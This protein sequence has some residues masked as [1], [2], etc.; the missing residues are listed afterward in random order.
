[1]TYT[2]FTGCSF[3][4]GIGLE[5]TKQSPDLWVNQVYNNI[6]KL[7]STKLLNLGVGGASNSEIFHNTINAIGTYN[8]KYLFVA[9]TSFTRYKIN[10]GIELYSTQIYLSP[11]TPM[12][13]VHLN[14]NITYSKEFLTK[15]KNNMLMLNRDHYHYVEILKYTDTIKLLCQKLNIG[16]FFI[17]AI[18]PHD[19]NYFTPVTHN[20]RVPTDTTV[21][22]QEELNAHARGDDEFFSIYDQ[23]H[24]AYSKTNGLSSNWL[25]L[26]S[27][28]YKE[29]K[30]DLGLDNFHP[31]I[32]SHRAFGMHLIEKLH[33]QGLS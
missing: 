13:D 11:G 3:T 27:G 4:E 18:L 17:N 16:V 30:V 9:W 2:I 32:H 33:E 12:I 23:V 22:T 28:F 19:R 31:G 15:F 7:T 6:S 24:K 10:P 21:Y 14:P 1:M 20:N 5:N 8:C 26:D 29:F 25:N